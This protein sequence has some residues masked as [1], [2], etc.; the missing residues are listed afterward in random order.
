MRLAEM[1]V[2]LE[3]VKRGVEENMG[4]DRWVR[5]AKKNLGQ[6]RKAGMVEKA[7]VVGKSGFV[8]EILSGGNEDGI[9]GTRGKKMIAAEEAN[10]EGKRKDRTRRQGKRREEKAEQEEHDFHVRETSLERALMNSA[11]PHARYCCR[12]NF[13]VC[14]VRAFLAFPYGVLY[15]EI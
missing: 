4:V 2:A 9:C 7:R 11:A 13:I 15:L 1:F 10:V 3:K 14:S 6:T 12:A 8:K 5:T